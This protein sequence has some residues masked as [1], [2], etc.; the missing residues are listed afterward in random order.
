LSAV[1]LADEA[2]SRSPQTFGLPP[3]PAPRTAARLEG[4]YS[5]PGGVTGNRNVHWQAMFRVFRGFTGTAT[6]V[7][8]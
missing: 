5:G 2:L 1:V 6:R 7:I 3:A 8:R 4:Q